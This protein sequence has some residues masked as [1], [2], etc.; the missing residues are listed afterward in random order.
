M[1]SH[2]RWIRL[3]GRVARR[4]GLYVRRLRHGQSPFKADH[5]H[6][7][8]LLR[9]SGFT[10]MQKVIF[11]CLFSALCGLVAGQ[12]LRMDI[13]EPLLL[14]AFFMMCLGWFWLTSRH[15]RTVRF[16]RVGRDSCKKQPDGL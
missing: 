6:V 14:L 1:T 15:D 11:L 5:N 2:A 8:H 7:H 3:A 16:L 4:G 12:A 10:P 9:G 13:P